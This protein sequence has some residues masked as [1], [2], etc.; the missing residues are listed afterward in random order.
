MAKNQIEPQNDQEETVEISLDDAT[1]AQLMWYSKYQ[2]N[3]DV[4]EAETRNQTYNRLKAAWDHPTIKVPAVIPSP[5]PAS[6]KVETVTYTADE[7]YGLPEFVTIIAQ[8]MDDD[9]DDT[10]KLAHQG[11]TYI[12]QKGKEVTIPWYVYQGCIVDA[13]AIVYQSGRDTGLGQERYVQAVQY[14]RI[15]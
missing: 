5:K 7:R 3:L 2:M 13:K 10:L 6:Q 9:D 11:K 14:T 15:K 8:G 12:I 1:H 4:D